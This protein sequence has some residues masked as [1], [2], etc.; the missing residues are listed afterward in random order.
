MKLNTS[1]FLNLIS[2]NDLKSN[3]IPFSMYTTEKDK[4]INN[5]KTEIIQNLQIKELL[6]IKDNT[7]LL[8]SIYIAN[9]NELY[10]KNDL[11]EIL[12]A[13]CDSFKSLEKIYNSKNTNI[14]I[15]N[16][17]EIT[18]EIP[19]DLL[20]QAILDYISNLNCNL[21]S[22]LNTK[23]VQI[24]RLS[25]SNTHNIYTDFN[26]IQKIKMVKKYFNNFNLDIIINDNILE[27]K[28]DYE[29]KKE[30]SAELQELKEKLKELM[31][32]DIPHL[33]IY[34][35]VSF[36]INQVLKK[37]N[38]KLLI[39]NNYSR[40]ELLHF[41]KPG[42]YCKYIKNYSTLNPYIPYG[43][44]SYGRYMN[45][46]IKTPDVL[47]DYYTNIYMKKIEITSENIQ[48]YVI[49]SIFLLLFSN[50]YIS[51][52]TFKKI[53]SNYINIYNDS[54]CI[55]YNSDSNNNFCEYNNIINK[56]ENKFN[57]FLDYAIKNNYIIQ[58]DDYNYLNLEH[59]QYTK[60]I[61]YFLEL[62]KY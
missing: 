57:T 44:N 61:Q 24:N 17:L 38:L 30:E 20:N 21:N 7:F 37:I 22:N 39:D 2:A 15:S 27:N 1:L 56:L 41:A 23:I 3:N 11:K 60:F 12:F 46:V 13:L 53:I 35:N 6:N 62:F 50:T 18:L 8:D 43:I 16:D 4:Y 54:N 47:N 19:Y 52:L 42:F 33:S 59:L 34:S 29:N 40:Y 51:K 48:D 28:V 25:I 5:L 26:F 45:L 55:N 14:C 49:N 10:T 9:F 36:E 31:L 32:L 58:K